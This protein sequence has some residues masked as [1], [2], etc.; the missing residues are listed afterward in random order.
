ML[1]RDKY[2]KGFPLLAIVRKPSFCGNKVK[3]NINFHKNLV[4]SLDLRLLLG[5]MTLGKSVLKCL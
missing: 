2:A 5:F 3:L 1:T 4:F